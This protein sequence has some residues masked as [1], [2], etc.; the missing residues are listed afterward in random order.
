MRTAQSA[1]HEPLATIEQPDRDATERAS[2]HHQ[3]TTN[4]RQWLRFAGHY[5]EMVVAMLV[6]MFILGGA[7]RAVLAL[8]GVDYSMDL[9]PGLVTLEMGVTMA[10]AMLAWMRFRGHSWA[11]TL[12]MAGAML[13][14]AV[15]AVPLIALSVLDAGT[16]MTVEHVAMFTLMLVVMLRRRE[17]YVAH[18]HGR[19]AG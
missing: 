2:R 5:L 18:T 7:L 4:R 19:A 16:A 3:P 13:A 15:A 9:Y 1:H 8:A 10:A 14:P 12:E 6:G 17:E 11:P